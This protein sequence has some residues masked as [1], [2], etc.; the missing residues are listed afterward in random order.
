[1]SR[2]DKRR[3]RFGASAHIRRRSPAAAERRINAM[4]RFLD[5]HELTSWQWRIV[6]DILTSRSRRAHLER[7]A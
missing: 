6:W 2:A 5:G 7:R 3:A 4:L 1:M